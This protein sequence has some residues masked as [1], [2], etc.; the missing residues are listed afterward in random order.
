M[1]ETPTL[2]EWAEGKAAIRR[3]MDCFYDRVER[4]ELLSPYF[5]GG[6][7]AERRADV[8]AWS[9]EVL[10][11]TTG[12][13]RGPGRLLRRCSPTIGASRSRPRRG[14]TSSRCS[15]TRPTTPASRDPGVPLGDG[16]LRRGDPALRCTT[17]SRTPRSSSR[18]LSLA[19]VWARPHPSSHEGDVR[20][21]APQVG[22]PGPGAWPHRARAP[23]GM[24]C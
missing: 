20:A 10:G 1:N 5:P 6:V 8:A 2:S 17:P 24:R 9:S 7:G 23:E 16:R 22:T 19:G 14:I 11:S 12:Y 3:L 21:R 4:D 15:A 18:R 13:D